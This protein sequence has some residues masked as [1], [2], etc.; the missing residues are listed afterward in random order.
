MRKC[1]SGRFLFASLCVLP[2]FLLGAEPGTERPSL[3][4]LRIDQPLVLSGK[5]DSP[6][7]LQ[8]DS[9]EL[10]YEVTPGENTPAPQKTTVRALYDD[11]TIYFGFRCLDTRP[12]EIRANLSD[13]DRMYQDDWVFVGIDTYGDFQRSYE[14]CVNPLGIQGDLLATLN[15]E[16]ASVDWIWQA[17]AGRS[18][19]GWTAELAIP[20]SSLTFPDAEVQAWRINL[21]RTVP[22]ASR[23]Q[24]SWARLDRS[25]PGIMTQAGHLRGV[26]GIRP[27]SSLE[28]LPYA[29]GLKTGALSDVEDPHS[30]F[31]RDPFRGRV[32][33]GIKYALG[34]DVAVD[35]VIN[36]D[37]SQI[38][39]DA[40]QISVNTTFALQYEEKRPFFL[41]GRELLQTPMYYSRSINDPAAAGRVMGKSGPVSYMVMSAYDRNTVFDIPG[42]DE[43]DVVG[44]GLKSFVN[45]ARV[46]WDVV[47]QSYAGAMLLARNLS[48]GHNY[49]AGID[50]T[51][52]FWNNWYF[53][54]E[55]FLSRT[56]EP[57]DLSVLD[58]GREY[59]RT[60]YDA[61]FNGEEYSG[62][63]IHASLSHAG[64]SYGFGLTLNN[65]SP[66]YQTYNGSFSQNAY[67]QIY[68]NHEY[69]VYPESSFVDRGSVGVNTNLQFDW[70]GVKKEQFIQPYV[71]LSLKGQT[72]VYAHGLVLYDER[73]RGT[74]F[75]GI[76]KF[77]CEVS[78]RPLNEITVSAYA[79]VGRFIR[80]SDEPVL[81][82]G[83]NLG[84]SVTLK[85]GSQWNIG[86]VYDRARLADRA[87]DEL[88]YDGNIYR[89]VM[90][91][92]HSAELFFRAI[93]QY[94][95]FEQALQLYPL[96][97]YKLNAFTTLYAGATGDYVNY[98]S[99][100]GMAHTA[101]Q[102]FLKVQYLVAM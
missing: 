33:G 95:S 48:G 17:A 69:T 25:I 3:N 29:I 80:R 38:E 16:D 79:Y 35:A 78:S 23:T 51:A 45:I 68:M 83:H 82:R 73:F 90:I 97:S 102:Y 88:F 34:P 14:F 75:S 85:P 58:A 89:T 44:S 5:L 20:F 49:V 12:G 6:L 21:L 15:S 22:R 1:P 61:A 8:A 74:L 13:R 72:S 39:T 59:G 91:Y 96:L 31:V 18:E 42:E 62:N 81:G 52:K 7:W 57:D 40:A 54:G 71:S 65:F 76:H 77:Y 94:N 24:I 9:V 98:G 56:R 26:R 46:R 50:W 70:Y 67:R 2:G 101:E 66:T 30:G 92:Q 28:L 100:T 64:R 60:G 93:V 99:P 86:F 37:F 43:S 41:I 53:S 4:A 19:G 10:A 36:P 55:G 87:S 32:G 84:G 47:D 27:A 63:G 11:H